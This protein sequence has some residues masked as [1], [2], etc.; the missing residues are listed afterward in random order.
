MRC[1][2]QFQDRLFQP[3]T[4]PSAL[5][6]Y[7]ASLYDGPP[8]GIEFSRCTVVAHECFQRSHSRQSLRIYAVTFDTS[9]AKFTVPENCLN[10]NV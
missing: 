9:Y 1:L 2:G 3:L 8:A 5:V 10:H 6:M 4:H 7:L